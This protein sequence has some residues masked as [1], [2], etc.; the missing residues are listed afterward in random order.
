MMNKEGIKQSKNKIEKWDVTN[1]IE[2]QTK[3]Q[4]K[5]PFIILRFIILIDILLDS[6]K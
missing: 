2:E 5:I 1:E 6:A 3:L 4:F